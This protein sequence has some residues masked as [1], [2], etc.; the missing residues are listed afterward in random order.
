MRL[1]E[2]QGVSLRVRGTV[3]WIA[4]I[5]RV[6]AVL[7]M[8]AMLA[9]WTWVIFA[10]RGKAVLPAMQTDAVFSAEHLFGIAAVSSVTAQSA[11]PN[12]RL[13][14]VFAGTPGFAIL[15]LNGKHQ[16]GLAVGQDVVAGAKLVEVAID[17]VV[18]E[19]SGVRQQIAFEGK[20]TAIKSTTAAS[21][22]TIPMPISV[23]VIAP[24]VA[25]VLSASAVPDTAAKLY[26]PHGRGGL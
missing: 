13:V 1:P 5:W 3:E 21:V 14:G 16:L 25:S 23:S 11:L 22:Q 10:P 9:N 12:V 19:R 18:I 6:L 17:H 26:M 24:V 8:G 15:E 7:V 4:F 20:T 2:I